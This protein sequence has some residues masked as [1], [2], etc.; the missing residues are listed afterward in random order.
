VKEPLPPS[1]VNMPVSVAYAEADDALIVTM[2]RILGLCWAYDYERTPVLT[3]EQLTE[4]TGRPRSTLYRHLKLLREMQWI[5]VDQAGRR[6]FIRP[7]IVRNTQIVGGQ[8]AR[9]G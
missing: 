8:L 1:Y 2:T 4:F 6:I 9:T 5:R 7:I 3:P